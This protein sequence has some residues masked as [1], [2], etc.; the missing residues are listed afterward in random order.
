P[1]FLANVLGVRTNIIGLIEGL[2]E[3][4][5][6]LLKLFSGW[7]SDRLRSRKWITVAGYSLSAFAKPFLLIANSWGAV[8]AV[9]L[10]DRVGKGIRNS[11]RDALI[12]DSID[13]TQRGLAFGLHRAG[14]TAGAALGLFIALIVVT[15]SQRGRATLSSNTFYLLV[16]ISVIPAVLGVLAL[17]VGA[18]DVPLKPDGK[19]PKLS[20]AGFDNRFKF[21]L[22]VVLI[23][24]FGNSSDAFLV[25]RAQER[26]MSVSTIMAMILSFN[27]LYA[28]LSGPAGRLSDRLGRQQLIITGWAVYGLV[29]LGFALAGAGWQ[30]FGLYILYGAYYGLTEGVSKAFIADLVAPEQRGTAYGLYN[31]IVGV[32]ALPASFIAG[33]LWQGA[34]SFGGF[35]PHAPFLFGAILALAASVMLGVGLRPARR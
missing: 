29:Y 13:E 12:A 9:R 2:A 25:L 15:L 31:A 4:T 32:A 16:A 6:S 10:T 19:L 7:L 22:L 26:G 34:G 14:D 18:K 28:L 1:L 35:G 3:T 11:P 27:I 21:F 24:T 20:L 17:I 5:A 8:L 33:L 30:V 23:F